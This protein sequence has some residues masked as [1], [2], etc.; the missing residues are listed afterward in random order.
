[1][2]NTSKTLKIDMTSKGYARVYGR[3][4]E[5]VQSEV[6]QVA[7]L[8]IITAFALILRLY[9][10]GEWSFW[11]DE[12]ITVNSLQALSGQFPQLG[13]R[14]SNYLIFI[15]MTIFGVS[16]WS[17]RLAPAL[18]GVLTVPVLFFLVRRVY[19]AGVATLSALLLSLST[20]HLYWSQNAR[21]YTTLLLFYIL[22]MF[23]FYMGIE[24]DRPLYLIL[25]LI[26][27]GLAVQ[28][29]LFSAA[30]V[31]IAATYLIMIKWLPYEKPAGFKLRNI[32]ILLVPSALGG[33]AFGLPYLLHPEKWL[34]TFSWI[35]NSPFWIIAGVVYYIGLSLIVIGIVSALYMLIKFDRAALLLSLAA[36]FPFLAIVGLSFFQYTANR[37]VFVSLPPIII[38]ASVGIQRIFSSVSGSGRW[39]V[40]GLLL[41]LIF[42]PMSENILY[43]TYQFGNRENG[44]AA[45]EYIQTHRK[46]GDRV[47]LTDP[48]VGEYYLGE[49]VLRVRRLDFNNLP[50]KDSRI[51]LIEDN[52]MVEKSPEAVR[53][54]QENADLEAIYDN[55]VRGRNFIMRIY[56]YQAGEG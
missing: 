4:L 48:S 51:W 7:I 18:V 13:M 26:F 14:V 31:P 54:L 6:G 40:L 21:F 2:E 38:L 42:E 45:F 15:P 25:S 55:Q 52:N 53:W 33:L 29:R 37:Y 49:T 35:N 24:K 8:I 30:L 19:G 3:L 34:K 43:Y 44:K 16:E 1:M 36:L 9:K 22:A 47:A 41:I 56:L 23:M 28:E 46:P 12:V 27:F 11:G 20:W 39:L 5:L 32:L 50:V 17:A 10:I